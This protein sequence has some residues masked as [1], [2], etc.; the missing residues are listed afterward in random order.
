MGFRIK[1]V[2]E[3][4]DGYCALG[5][6]VGDSFVIER[7]YILPG[8]VKIC[9]HAFSAMLTLLSAFIHGV[10]ADKLGIGK[11]KDVGFLQCPD[12][13]KPYTCG[14]TVLFKLIR[15]GIEDSV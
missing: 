9:I 1:V 14:G 5:Y 13:G 6:K 7:Y 8:N 3:K 11:D 4:V 15:E 10:D 12:P 2:V